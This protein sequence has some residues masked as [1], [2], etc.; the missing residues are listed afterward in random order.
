MVAMAIQKPDLLRE[1]VGHHPIIVVI[2]DGNVFAPRPRQPKIRGFCDIAGNGAME[3]LN[4]SVA[5]S[6]IPP[7]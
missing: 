2:Q 7:S 3:V 4:A 5:L 6:A 1:L